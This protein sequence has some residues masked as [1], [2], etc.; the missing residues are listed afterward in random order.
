MGMGWGRKGGMRGLGGWGRRWK[1]MVRGWGWGGG[2]GLRR[3][4]GVGGGLVGWGGGWGRWVGFAT[5]QANR[6]VPIV[7]VIRRS[8]ES[9]RYCSTVLAMPV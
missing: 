9:C 2:G 3:G 5:A 8:G 6:T 1:L 4:V 7:F